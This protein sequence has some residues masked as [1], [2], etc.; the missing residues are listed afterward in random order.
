LAYISD[1][2]NPK[3]ILLIISSF[4]ATTVWF[5]WYFGEWSLMVASL[6]LAVP[7]MILYAY[8]NR[9]ARARMIEIL[10]LLFFYLPLVI[11]A[12][13]KLYEVKGLL[14]NGETIHSFHASLYFSVV[15]WTTLGYGDFQPEESVRLWAA[16]E[17]LFGYVCMAILIALIM[18]L[19]IKERRNA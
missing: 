9:G 15:T 4:P 8:F 6:L 12:F 5:A 10:M 2:V 16:T 3:K 19:L 13:A 18:A 7:I 14:Y 11:Y 1:I 17:A